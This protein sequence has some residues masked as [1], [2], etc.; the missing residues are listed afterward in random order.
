[1][2]TLFIEP[3]FLVKSSDE[4]E[5]P[6]MPLLEQFGHTL[7]LEKEYRETLEAFRTKVTAKNALEAK[8]EKLQI[9]AHQLQNLNKKIAEMKQ[10]YQ[11]HMDTLKSTGSADEP[12]GNTT[13][14]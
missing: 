9:E 12:A 14:K 5:E 11:T 7:E 4:S 1:M 2:D 3:K 8:H 13:E 10:D 6:D